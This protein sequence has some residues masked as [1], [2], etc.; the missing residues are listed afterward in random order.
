V[1]RG[2]QRS[3][4]GKGVLPRRRVAKVEGGIGGGWRGRGGEGCCKGGGWACGAS[5]GHEGV[6]KGDVERRLDMGSK[7]Q[8]HTAPLWLCMPLRYQ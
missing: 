5:R 8:P 2:R 4:G 7:G 6:L 3:R 1:A